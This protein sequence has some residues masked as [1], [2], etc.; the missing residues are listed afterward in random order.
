MYS[1][2]E[3]SEEVQEVT[4]QRGITVQLVCISPREPETSRISFHKGGVEFTAQRSN[5]RFYVSR[6]GLTIHK[7]KV[8]DSDEYSCHVWNE[9]RP[10]HVS[11]RSLKL[12]VIGKGRNLEEE[13]EE[14]YLTVMCSGGE[15]KKPPYLCFD[16]DVPR[17]AMTSYVV[18]PAGT[19]ME[20]FCNAKGMSKV[21]SFPGCSKVAR[22]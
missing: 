22:V 6:L 15:E 5:G 4:V 8:K 16:K 11:V 3:L 17:R 21:V 12:N 10:G 9:E 18:R 1:I 14:E 2:S 19:T 20:L 7:L 13:E